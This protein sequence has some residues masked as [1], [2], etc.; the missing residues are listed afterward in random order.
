VGIL[1]VQGRGSH[2]DKPPY[3]QGGKLRFLDVQPLCQILHY[4]R[5]ARLP[6][7]GRVRI[8]F[9]VRFQ[10][11]VL[12]PAP[13]AL[14][15]RFGTEYWRLYDFQSETT[16]ALYA[17]DRFDLSRPG[18]FTVETT[19]G[20]LSAGYGPLPQPGLVA[21]AGHYY[22]LIDP[23]QG[24]PGQWL[25]VTN[26]PAFFDQPDVVRKLCFTL[27]DLSDFSLRLTDFQSTWQPGGPLRVRVVVRDAD[28]RELPVVNVR[29]TAA[30]GSWQTTLSTE[31][32][33]L[34][35][36]TGWMRGRLPQDHLPVQ[37]ELAAT[38][39]LATPKGL[40]ER[41]VRATVARGTGLLPPERFAP[42]DRFAY[43]LPR[44][45]KGVVRETRA[46][47][48]STDD[49]QSEEQIDRLVGRCRAARLNVLFPDVFV[50]NTFAARSELLP[51]TQDRSFDPLRRL[52][53]KAHRAG[54]EVHPWFCVTYRD[55]AFRKWFQQTHGT[56]VEML[57][58]DGRVIRFG[59]DIHRKAYRDFVVQ[60]MVGVAR[61]Y[62][63]DGIHLDYIRSMGQ[64][65]CPLCR[66]EFER[67]FGKPLDE[68]TDADWTKWQ[69][70]AVGDI[71]RRTAEG[72]RKVRPRAILSAAVFSNMDSGARQGQDP[73]GWAAKGWLDLVV[74]MD[75][76]MQSVAVRA[77]ERRFLAALADDDRLAT[78]LS[79]YMRSGSEVHP[80]PARL[81][82]E[83]IELVRWLGIHGYS[84]F[85]FRHLS[86]E[87]LQ[88][89]REQVNKE[90]AVPYFRGD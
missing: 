16:S 45:E 84:L 63:V 79:L 43:Q 48:V 28:G 66:R 46:I 60:L 53:Q 81:V 70:Q 89:L 72:V 29:L 7:G 10:Y 18:T 64:C 6:K 56:N 49:F 38:V 65:Y 12:R 5:P 33:P 30:A 11:E 37:V 23:V 55:A 90:P 75:Y 41:T 8:P 44:N 76:Q 25:D 67:Q 24:E 19:T 86:D 78:G 26:P 71:V 85:A 59:A 36:P 2:P 31:W 14:T 77:N 27:A 13:V 61:D 62:P 87:Q 54:L 42:V 51:A 39:R 21:V 9:P 22:F 17:D 32:L 68:A 57:D 4:Q 74:P 34:N 20:W 73:A 52:I 83:Q 69:R 47:W 50:R 88:V 58:A 35:Q 1:T 82:R 40:V 3:R 15:S 80:R